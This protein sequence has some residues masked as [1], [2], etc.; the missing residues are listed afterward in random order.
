MKNKKLIFLIIG[1]ILIII[2]LCLNFYSIYKL[3]SLC[4]GIIL[5]DIGVFFNKKKSIFMMIYL[6]ILILIFTYALDYMKTYTLNISPVYILENKINDKISIY[7]SL[8]YRIYKCDNKYIFDN[9][10][11]KDF[12]CKS[13]M[14]DNIDINKLLN[15]PHESYKKYH[16]DFIKVTGKISK[17]NGISSIELKEYSNSD[18]LNG[19]VKFN[20]TKKLTINIKNVNITKYKIYD[21][22][23][24]VGLLKDFKNNNEL[25]LTNTKIEENNLYEKYDLQVLE[26]NNCNKELKEYTDNIYTYCLDNIFLNYEID[27][28]ELSYAIKDKKITL[29][30]LI[31]D[32]ESVIESDNKLYKL[33]KFN[34]LICQNDKNIL[35]NKKEKL[36]YSLC[37]E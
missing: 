13:E 12:M 24:V 17:I 33:D 28:Y 27:K 10:Y 20:D 35:L 9:D 1:I 32:I 8:F 15:E 11:Q 25:V 14:L 36:D 29:N 5:I 23:T 26:T 4:L 18:S 6:P 31:K 34:I 16:N 22:I 30:D 19:Y 7:N 21:Y 37:E 3:L 2:P